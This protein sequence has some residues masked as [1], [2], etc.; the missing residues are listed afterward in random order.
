MTLVMFEAGKLTSVSV[1]LAPL[2][3]S[4]NT[5]MSRVSY[6]P[7]SVASKAEK[8]TYIFINLIIYGDQ[9]ISDK[10]GG[11]PDSNKVFL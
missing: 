6:N 3:Q 2:F 4:H 11:I 7:F 10:V 8:N 9:D 5:V 1:L